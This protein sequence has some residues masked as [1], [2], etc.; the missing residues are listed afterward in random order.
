MK[1]TGNAC[2][3]ST[4]I[5]GWLSAIRTIPGGQFGSIM[6]AWRAI[7]FGVSHFRRIC[8]VCYGVFTA[9]PPMRPSKAGLLN[10]DGFGCLFNRR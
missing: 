5:L 8:R 10:G 3:R 4:L 2:I 7:Q 1:A 9:S 6:N